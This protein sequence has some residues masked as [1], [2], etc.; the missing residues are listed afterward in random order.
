MSREIKNAVSENEIKVVL[1]S[2]II[3]AIVTVVCSSCDIL[4]HYRLGATNCSTF[5]EWVF[6]GIRTL[7]SYFFPT[8]FASTLNF[9]WQYYLSENWSG[10]KDKK[11]II[12]S[13]GCF[14]YFMMYIVYLL[15]D[16]SYY[17]I[18]FTIINVIYVRFVYGCIDDRVFKMS[19]TLMAN[20]INS[21]PS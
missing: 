4:F 7:T 12:L 20:E 15:F 8:I 16:E 9:I 18:A 21:N 11:G 19:N 6:W 2:L 5:K 10:I 14:A 3:P 17:I 1:A 13:L